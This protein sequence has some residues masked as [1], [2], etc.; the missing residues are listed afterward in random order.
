[1]TDVI[2]I[3]GG[4]AG[5][6]AALY[7]GRAGLSTLLIEKLFCG[8]QAATTYEVDNY[9]GFSAP[10]SGPD[11]VSRMEEHARRF[12]VTIINKTVTSLSVEGSVKKV[13]CGSEAYEAKAVIVCGGASPR[14]LGLDREQ[15]LRGSG[16]SYCATCDG[17]FFRGR[18]VAVVGGGDTAV[19]DALFLANFCQ[20]VYLIH[21]R[22]S[23][24][25]AKVLTDQLY[26]NEKIT[27]VLDSVVT[28][29]NGSDRLSG[30]TVQNKK[31]GASSE[32]AVSA[33]FVAVGTVPDSEPYRGILAMDDNGY[34]ITDD[35]MR[36]SCDGVFAAGDIRKKS[37]RQ[38]ITAA[39]D[40]AVAANS[41]ITY[42]MQTRA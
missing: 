2:I 10:I 38:I 35:D 4:P 27:L 22:D 31:S 7:A 41:A 25:A 28:G 39:S 36:T 9:I 32:L 33:V 12:G 6:N 5:L 37:L 17:A 30:L 3:G 23:F 42:L 18:D 19:E 34:L 29:L 1:M 14:M 8:G 20:T 26:K 13:I 40:G 21:R 15:Q 24:R 11:L 16:V